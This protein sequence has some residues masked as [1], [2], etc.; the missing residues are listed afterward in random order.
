MTPRDAATIIKLQAEAEDLKRGMRLIPARWAA[1]AAASESAAYP[2]V[3]ILTKG[4]N[5][6]ITTPAEV[7]GVK[8]YVGEAQATEWLYTPRRATAVCTISSGAVNSVTLSE[9]G[10]GYALPSE[11]APVVTVGPPPGGGTQ[12]VITATVSDGGYVE[13]AYITDCGTL[14][15][16]T[17]TVT[18]AAPPSGVTATGTARLRDGKVVY[19]TMTNKGS[20]YVTAPTVTIG[21]SDGGGTLATATCVL[22]K[23]KVSLAITT[24]GSGYLTAPTVTVAAPPQLVVPMPPSADDSSPA[25]WPDGIGWGIIQGGSLTGGLAVSVP[26]LICHD[27]RSLV[28]WGLM[29]EGGGTVPLSRPPDSMLSWYLTYIR[30]T[31][32]DPD[33]DG[34]LPAWVPMSGGV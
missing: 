30:L 25:D 34:V 17:P 14:Y 8:R 33:A 4:G 11:P 20:G 15:N 12:A 3:Q 31:I 2:W 23:G 9:V 24:A 5:T 1:V 18:F 7:Y 29:G 6:L 22:G 13:G 26:G 32:A 27:D 16:A 21:A 10:Q 28:P 19:I